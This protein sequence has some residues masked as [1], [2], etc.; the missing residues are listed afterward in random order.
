MMMSLLPLPRQHPSPPAHA[1]GK[2][3]AISEALHCLAYML[4]RI[5]ILPIQAMY[6]LLLSRSTKETSPVW[7]ANARLIGQRESK[8]SDIVGKGP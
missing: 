4:L 3:Q 6:M 2:Q 5:I 1:H 7:G 8:Q